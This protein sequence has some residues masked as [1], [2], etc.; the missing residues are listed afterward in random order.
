MEAPTH[1]FL[2]PV[3]PA[4]DLVAGRRLDRLQVGR[5]NGVDAPLA[6]GLSLLRLGTI[7]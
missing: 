1:P 5:R 2:I 4:L 7:D 6:H 3:V